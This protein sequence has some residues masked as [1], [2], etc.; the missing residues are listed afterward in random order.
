VTNQFAVSIDKPPG[1]G[2][3]RLPMG[4]PKHPGL[5]TAL[6]GK[7]RDLAEWSSAA[8]RELLGPQAGR[9]QLDA[10]AETLTRLAAGGRQRGTLF[11]YAWMAGPDA[12]ST[13]HIDI[14]VVRISRA[15]PELTLDMLQ[16]MYTNRD[17]ADTIVLDV[18]RTELPAGPAVRLHRRWQDGHDPSDTVVSVAYLCRPPQIKP[19]VNFTMYWLIGDDDPMLTEYADT[20]AATLKI[21]VDR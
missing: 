8:A 14:S 12:L 5:L 21:T 15:I 1:Q 10:R 13:A 20:L 3:V 7:N 4:K 2:W 18:S 16:E 11:K 6:R 9:E 17:G 19:A